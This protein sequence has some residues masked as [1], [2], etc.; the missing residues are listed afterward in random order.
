MK[1]A[2]PV[3]PIG[4]E[5]L[6]TLVAALLIYK[7]YRREKTPSTQERLHTLL[8]LEFLIP[9]LYG[10]LCPHQ[11]ATP[12]WLTIDEVQVMKAGLASLLDRLS[13]K[14]PSAAIR[15]EMQRLR[16]L[17]AVIEQTFRTTQDEEIPGS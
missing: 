14:P 10:A 17:K 12:L 1:D 7:H 9:K 2:L 11:E 16:E 15:K 8:T 13:R 6:R 4:Q 5:Q 3:L